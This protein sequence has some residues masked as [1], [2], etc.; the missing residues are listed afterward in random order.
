MTGD[1]EL[2][3]ELLEIRKHAGLMVP[4]PVQAA[5]TAA[6]ADD[7]HAVEQRARYAARRSALRP[8]LEAAG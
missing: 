4:G 3:G 1:P 8:A 5:M 7:A 2:I 6:L